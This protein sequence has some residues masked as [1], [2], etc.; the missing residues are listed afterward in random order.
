MSEDRRVVHC[1]AEAGE[2][3]RQREELATIRPELGTAGSR[4]VGNAAWAVADK[5][6]P[7]QI[8][9]GTTAFEQAY[10]L[11]LARARGKKMRC[12]RR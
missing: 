5:C 6:E 8:S 11:E 2:K 4:R 3:K 1:Q 10:S 12:V 7:G 9:N